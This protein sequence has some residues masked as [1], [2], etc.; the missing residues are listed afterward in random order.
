[1]RISDLTIALDAKA[2]LA[3][4]PVWHAA[5]QKL[6]WIDIWRKE[7]HRFDPASGEDECRPLPETVGALALRAKGGVLLAL[8]N[9]LA[10]LDTWDSELTPFGKPVLADK[11][12]QRFN[13]GCT[14]PAGRFWVGTCDDAKNPEASLYRVD[15]DGT[16]TQMRH[17]L[18][19]ANAAA[20]NADGSLFVHADTPSH[21]LRLYDADM[22]EG[23]INNCRILRRFPQDKGAPD[24]GWFD[25]EG[26]YWSASFSLEPGCGGKVV[27][28][29]PKGEILEAVPI[30]T[31]R[32]TMIGFGGEDMCTAYVTTARALLTEE[33]LLQQPDAGAIFS[34]RVDVPGVPVTPFLG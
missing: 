23:T 21:V 17:G 30:P 12:D 6:Y 7:L 20:F 32:T 16:I 31:P 1:M 26:C 34:F 15:P 22:A 25:M 8:E 33:E 4:S 24:G 29:S 28:L 3:E 19:T 2:D 27:K 18:V 13:D 5:E 14:D 10:T 11:P 9:G